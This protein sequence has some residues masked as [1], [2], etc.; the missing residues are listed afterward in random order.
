MPL[1]HTYLSYNQHLYSHYYLCHYL[2]ASAGRDH[3]SHSLLKFKKGRQPD[4]EGWLDCSLELFARAPIPPGA[5]IVRALHHDETTASPNPSSLDLLGQ[6]LARRLQHHYHP[7]L[8]QKTHPTQPIKLFSK[9]RR[10]EELRGLYLIDTSYASLLPDPPGHWII[11]DDILTSGATI[12]AI[13]RAIHQTYPPATT[14]I[15]IFTLTRATTTPPLHPA[16]LKG[17][18]YRFEEDD[19]TWTLADPPIPYYSLLQ[20]KSKI[21]SDIF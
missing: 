14:P 20:L 5:T 12:R 19:T 8:L 9:P 18:H 21:L 4:L 1:H 6:Q 15:H 17:R 13:L 10:E 16:P 7:Q 3:L 11:I 2:P